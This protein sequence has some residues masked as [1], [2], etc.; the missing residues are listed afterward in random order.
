MPFEQPPQPAPDAERETRPTYALEADPTYKDFR[1]VEVTA[2]D[3]TK[4]WRPA[5]EV[6]VT[7][8]DGAVEEHVDAN[9]PM[10]TFEDAQGRTLTVTIAGAG[11]IDSTHIHTKELGG[12]FEQES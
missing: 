6:S 9:R 2:Y 7:K 5:L 8:A 4:P 1:K 11:H 3:E 10:Y 12:R